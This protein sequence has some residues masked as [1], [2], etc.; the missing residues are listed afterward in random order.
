MTH[1]SLFSG[2]GGFDF[3]AEAAGFTNIFAVENNKY[4]QS[5][6]KKNFSEIEIYGDIK[7]FTGE[8][9]AGSITV[10]SGGFPCQ[11]FSNAGKRKGGKDDRH[12]WHEMLRVVSEIKPAWVVIENVQGLLSIEKGMVFEQLLLDL[13]SRGYDTQAFNIPALA[14]NSPQIRK[15]IWIV[16]NSERAERQH[17]AC[18]TWA[19]RHRFANSSGYTSGFDI[20][21]KIQTQTKYS[22]A[23]AQGQNSQWIQRKHSANDRKYRAAIEKGQQQWNKR[24]LSAISRLCRVDDGLPPWMDKTKRIAALGNAIVPQIAYE[25]FDSIKEVIDFRSAQIRRLE[26]SAEQLKN[27]GDLCREKSKTAKCQNDGNFQNLNLIRNGEG[28]WEMT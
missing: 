5:I 1:G 20:D 12:L 15:R 8:V 23:T 2:I 25:I 26:S 9:Y 17:N 7:E 27:G 14:K 11:P 21:G 28:V 3:A 6:L 13:E 10:I 18:L 4:C 22:E 19:G 24:P 16:A